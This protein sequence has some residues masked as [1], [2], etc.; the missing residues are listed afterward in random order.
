MDRQGEFRTLLR[1][2]LLRR[3][4][5]NPTYSARAFA[6][7]L[8]VD[9]PTLNK[10]IRGK[11]P[12]GRITIERLGTRLGMGPDELAPYLTKPGR[13]KEPARSPSPDPYGQLAVDSFRIISDWH[14]Y[15]ILELLRLDHF[16]PD[17]AWVSKTLGI[18]S[19]DAPNSAGTPE[20]SHA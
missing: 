3:C 18:G 7:S 2:E 19:D 6:R 1:E 20:Q 16:R 12:T 11:R 5:K 9:A 10:I 8:G 15:A 13:R 4:R 17:P 14:H